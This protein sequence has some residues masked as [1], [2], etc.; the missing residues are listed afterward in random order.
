MRKNW[1]KPSRLEVS[2]D[3][4]IELDIINFLDEVFGGD[5]GK[6]LD[7]ANE[8][9]LVIKVEGVGNLGES[10]KASGFHEADGGIKAFDAHIK[11]R[12]QANGLD[13]AFFKLAFGKAERVQQIFDRHR[14][15]VAVDEAQTFFHQSIAGAGL[16][17]L[18]HQKVDEQ[19][20][21]GLIVGRFQQAQIEVSG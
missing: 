2:I 5:A 17:E 15:T 7:V 12:R 13:K 6:G 10:G 4:G 9:R 21:A 14:R 3:V 8:M 19:V 18:C 16:L 20:Q 1:K 11:M